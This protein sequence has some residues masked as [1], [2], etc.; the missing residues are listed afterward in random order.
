MI[1]RLDRLVL[2]AVLPPAVVCLLG[3]TFLFSA[4]G[5]N[6]IVNRFEVT[7]QASTLLA[8]APSLWISLLPMTLPVSVLLAAAMAFGRLRA[9]RELLLLEASGVSPWR[10]C[11]A[12]LGVGLVTALITGYAVSEMG[13]SAW[14][15]RNRMSREALADFIESPPP[16]ARELRFPGIDLSYADVRDGTVEELGIVLYNRDGLTAT[17]TAERARLNYDRQA[18]E[19]VLSDCV[20]PRYICY[21]P[22]SGVP[23]GPVV[24]AGLV[25]TLRV[26]FDFGGEADV[27]SPKALPTRALLERIGQDARSGAREQG[28]AAEWVRRIGLAAAGLLLPLLGALLASM[29]NHPN[30]L[31]AMGAG[32]V[33]SALLY[34]PLLT[35]AGSLAESGAL[36]AHAAAALTPA[37]TALAVL[38]LLWRRTR[39]RLF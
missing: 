21:E 13:P 3:L 32:V 39:G 25:R 38:L 19:L 9:D 1:P 34:F 37:A 27:D 17:V 14:S 4:V 12:L 30:R 10:P 22:K 7:P 6:Q 11:L 23:Q 28:A 20:N 24:T 31:L 36:S 18:G 16:G 5:L 15:A 35:A 29:V 2:R 33:P 26:G 8:F